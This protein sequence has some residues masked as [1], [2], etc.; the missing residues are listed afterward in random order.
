[1]VLAGDGGEVAGKVRDNGKPA[2]P[3]RVVLAPKADSTN[4]VDYK[5][6]QTESD[7][8]FRFPS[9]KPGEY[10]LYTT[11]DWKL[12]FG[13]PEAIRKYLKAGHPVHVAPKSSIDVQIE[14]TRP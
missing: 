4:S 3:V 2:F 9:I 5:S 12:E 1:M 13:N 10:I 7:G 6:Y 11:S 14:S 8:S